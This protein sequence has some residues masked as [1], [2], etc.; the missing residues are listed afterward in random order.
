MSRGGHEYGLVHGGYEAVVTQVGGSLR[1][2]RHHGRDLVRSY[3]PDAVRPR[4]S[5]A[6]LAPWPNRVA[7]GR[8]RF[9]GEEHQ[10]ALNEPARGNALHGLLL[11]DR[12]ELLDL[13]D[14]R[15]ILRDRLVARP[16]YPFDVD[17]MVSYSLAEDGLRVR[18]VGQNTG[19]RPAPWGVAS[20]PYLR[21]SAGRVDDW[22]LD[23]PAAEVL[24]VSPDRLLPTGTRSVAGSALDFRSPRRLG[25]T[26]M[27][28]AFTRL[29]ADGVGRC[30]VSL[31]GPDGRGSRIEWDPR[32][33]PWVQL[34]TADVAGS[35]LHR[36]GLAVE[37]MSCPP[38]AYNSRTDLVVLAPGDQHVAAWTICALGPAGDS[39]PGRTT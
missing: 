3:P 12:F 10:L 1:S 30:A 9:G 4:N 24:N 17:V 8:Y 5:G 39:T 33:L 25:S 29:G 36:T 35:E 37:P 20:H 27:D 31:T 13:A 19:D 6:V 28:H 22:T 11:W 15:V 38:D 16:G 18:V 2:L 21:G 26:R 14:S 7:D 23:V 34:H 32:V